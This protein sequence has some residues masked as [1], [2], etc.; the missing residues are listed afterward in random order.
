MSLPLL[1]T[2]VYIW[3]TLGHDYLFIFTRVVA[4]TG[5]ALAGWL[6]ALKTYPSS[7]S[8]LRTWSS[9]KVKKLCKLQRERLES[10]GAADKFWRWKVKVEKCQALKNWLKARWQ[11]KILT[12]STSFLLITSVPA[13]R[14]FITSS[15]SSSALSNIKYYKK[16]KPSIYLS[17]SPR[18]DQ[19]IVRWQSTALFITMHSP[20]N[21]QPLKI[22]SEKI[23]P[24]ICVLLYTVYHFHQNLPIILI[25]SSCKS[26]KN[27]SWIFKFVRWHSL[28]SF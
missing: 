15:Q 24:Q 11:K 19:Q 16:C 6:C 18:C 17:L 5:R 26:C 22:W 9:S 25:L 10:E 1:S 4:V 27:K 14:T 20:N 23:W 13:L 21:I 7:Q 8:F 12:R 2:Q 28:S 3:D